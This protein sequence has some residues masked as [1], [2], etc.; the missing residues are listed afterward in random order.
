MSNYPNLVPP[1]V[2]MSSGTARI[3]RQYKA[4]PKVVAIDSARA[5]DYFR[6]PG[7]RAGWGTPSLTEATEYELVRLSYD[8]WLMM[9]LYQNHWIVGKMIDIPAQDMV[10]AWP[11]ITSEIEPKDIEKIDACIRKT[12]VKSKLL[13]TIKLARL[14]GGA[15]ALIIIEGQENR[16][17]EPLDLES[18]PIHGFKGLIPFDRWSG[19]Y[20]TGQISTDI[21]KP[22]QFNLPQF[23]ECM[24]MNGGG[25]F[26]VHSSRILRFTGPE[27]PQPEYQAMN[28]WGISV[29]ERMYE[30]LRKRD[31]MS[32]NILNLS[33]RANLL[34]YKEPQLA[35]V[36]SGLNRSQA[37]Q[38]QWQSAMQAMNETLNTQNMLVLGKDAEFFS[39]NQSITGHAEIYEQ[40]QREIAGAVEMPVTLLYGDTKG[41]LNQTNDADFRIYAKKIKIDQDYQMRPQLEVLYPVI[42]MSEIGDVPGDID[43]RF[44]SILSLNDKEKADLAKAQGDTINGYVNSSVYTRSMALKDIK[45]TSDVTEIGTNITDQDIADAEKQDAEMPSPLEMMEAER[46]SAPLDSGQTGKPRQRAADALASRQFAGIDITI[47]YTR[48]VR[49]VLKNDAGNVVYDRTMQHD[50][51]F[52]DGTTGRDGDEVDCIV[53]RD[54]SA[55]FAYVADM[56]DLGPDV[57]KRSDEDKILLGFPDVDSA[58]AAFESMYPPEFLNGIEAVPIAA[59]RTKWLGAMDEFKESEHRDQID[60]R[61]RSYKEGNDG[62]RTGISQGQCQGGS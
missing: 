1:I 22:T 3:A 28:Y 39:V 16:L 24:T 38:M 25:T 57:D 44:P 53:G 55:R 6:N 41:G 50:Y 33:Y 27:V 37:S 52:I 8:Y 18:I 40:F 61:W 17:Q 30:E 42:M 21:T 7:T 13:K 36:L 47:E 43:L 5:N 4:D 56:K 32:W 2:G 45:Q 15:G 19:I 10:E 11:R 51:G 23:Y 49:R 29:V 54:E 34:A 59:F 9:T 12:H 62:A 35:Q 20:P 46:A 14:F 48:G 26:R 58:I 31:N 60:R